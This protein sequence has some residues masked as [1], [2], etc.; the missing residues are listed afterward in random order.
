M[1]KLG[2]KMPSQR[3]LRVGEVVRQALSEVFAREDLYNPVLAKTSITVSEVRISPDLK[4]ATAYVSP[5]GGADS[6]AVCRALNDSADA[7]RKLTGKKTYL[8]YAPKLFFKIDE[9]FDVAGR[10]HT[11]L[12]SD[13][14]K[15]DLGRMD[16]EE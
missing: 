7:I 11:I 8:K 5:L 4:N 3:Q 10:V 9:S 15:R 2:N 6:K 12:M 14:V 1:S 13:K 16:E